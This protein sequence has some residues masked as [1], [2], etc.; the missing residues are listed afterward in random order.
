MGPD[1]MVSSQYMGPD[2]MV[3]TKNLREHL[4]LY[5]KSVHGLRWNGQYE[6][7]KGTFEFVRQVST[8]AQMEWSIRR[9]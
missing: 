3:N 8:W 6:E 9:I 1:G 5:V 2:G 7:F 4:K